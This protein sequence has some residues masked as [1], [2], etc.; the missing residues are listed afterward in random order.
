MIDYL[1]F[2]KDGIMRSKGLDKQPLIPIKTIQTIM[3]EDDLTFWFGNWNAYVKFEKGLTLNKFLQNLEPWVDF[4]SKYTHVNI[5]E[6]IKESKKPTLVND[7]K[8]EIDWISIQYITDIDSAIEYEKSPS[9]REDLLSWINEPKNRRL[10]GKWE[11]DA[12]YKVTGYK[13][14]E[15]EHYSIDHTP[16]NKMANCEI[17]LDPNNYVIFSNYNYK[18][19]FEKDLVREDA[20][21]FVNYGKSKVLLG[22]K[23][24]RLKDVVEA[25]FWWLPATTERRDNFVNHLIELKTLVDSDLRELKNEKEEEV[26]EDNEETNKKMKIHFAE[27]AFDSLVEDSEH[28]YDYWT[29]MFE[30]AKKDK[31]AV[32][33]LGEFIEQPNPE[34]RM[35]NTI[36]P[37]ED[38]VPKATEYKMD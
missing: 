4:F 2:C 6:Y 14:G 24:H 36:K 22:N 33:K 28:Q 38:L 8:S 19:H 1:Y 3:E 7:D 13:Y 29:S 9:E 16:F 34:V 31:T 5:S 23:E 32:L 18:S 21:G 25:F 15:E 20:Y 17:V 10:T 12:H 35:F 37:E 11:V 30:A 27:G 26:T